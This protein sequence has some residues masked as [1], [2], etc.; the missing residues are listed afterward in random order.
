MTNPE[1]AT[2][3]I[4]ETLKTHF[5]KKPDKMPLRRHHDDNYW[6]EIII[7]AGPIVLRGSI[8]PRYKTSGLSGDEWR[9]S[10]RLVV[11]LHGKEV[12]EQGFHRMNDLLTHAPGFIWA[13]GN[14]LSIPSQAKLVCKRKGVMLFE[15]DF[16]TF[17]D[18]AM[19]MFWHVITANEGTKGVKWHHL[20]DEEERARCQQVGCAEPP[21]N[22]YRLKKLQVSRSEGLMVEPKYDFEGQYT[23]YC[24]RH[25][26]RG[27]C[28]LEDADDNLEL[29]QGSGVAVTRDVDESPSML[30]G[31]INIGKP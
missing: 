29:V 1:E 21:K 5:E 23:W 11:K 28:G 7:L 4:G 26:E 6:D 18:A 9:I 25:T 14:L 2:Q 10:A 12:L 19:P 31:I 30:G 22:F 3:R 24:S 17:G 16:P 20:S 8:V 15:R 13:N 27:D